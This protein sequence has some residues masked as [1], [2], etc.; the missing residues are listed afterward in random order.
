MATEGVDIVFYNLVLEI[1]IDGQRKSVVSKVTGRIRK[2]TMTV[3]MSRSGAGKTSFINSL[4]GRSFYGKITGDDE[5][6]GHYTTIEENTH[7][8]G[9]CLKTINITFAGNFQ[10]PAGTS[11]SKIKALVYDTIAYLG[12][13]H[14]ENTIVGDV[15]RSYH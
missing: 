10:L 1:L 12:Q 7:F 9:L 14:V 5:I 2:K 11:M 3:L 6:N 13:V 4:C 15:S 8:V